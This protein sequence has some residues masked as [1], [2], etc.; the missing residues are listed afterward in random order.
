MRNFCE[1]CEKYFSRQTNICHMILRKKTNVEYGKLPRIHSPSVNREIESL[2]II[3][4][5]H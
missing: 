1:V 4:G 2:R 3:V 5:L